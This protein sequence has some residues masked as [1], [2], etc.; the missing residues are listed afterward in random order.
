MPAPHVR[1]AVEEG[2]RAEE[3]RHVMLLA[4]PTLGLAATAKALTWIDDIVG[5]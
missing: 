3:I 4:L 1:R 5:P 2:I